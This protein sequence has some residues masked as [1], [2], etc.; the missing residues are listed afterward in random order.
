MHCDLHEVAILYVTLMVHEGW[1]D[2]GADPGE[3]GRMTRHFQYTDAAGVTCE[4]DLLVIRRKGCGAR[5]T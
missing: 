2:P 4:I 5:V 1:G 3:A